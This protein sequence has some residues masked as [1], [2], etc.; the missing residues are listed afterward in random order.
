MR[1]ALSSVR[2]ARGVGCYMVWNTAFPPSDN[3]NP[4]MNPSLLKVQFLFLALCPL[5]LAGHIPTAHLPTITAKRQSDPD[6]KCGFEG[7]SDAYGLGI[8]LAMYIQWVTSPLLSCF[9][10]EGSSS[11]IGISNCFQ[12]SVFIALVYM[13][14]T[15]GPALQVSEAYLMIMIGVAGAY[16]RPSVGV[17]GTIGLV[18]VRLLHRFDRKNAQAYTTA[19]GGA[20]SIVLG[21]ALTSYCLWFVFTGMD[22]VQ[23]PP[24]S[25]F[26]YLFARVD[27]YHGMRIFLQVCSVVTIVTTVVVSI[28]RVAYEHWASDSGTSTP[29]EASSADSDSSGTSADGWAR[30]LGKVERK[31]WVAFVGDMLA[32]SMFIL[33]IE[34][35]IRWN[36]IQGVHQMGSTGQILPFVVSLGS[37]VGV[38]CR[39]FL[40]IASVG[41]DVDLDAVST[42]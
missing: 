3:L 2:A 4:V 20:V 13:T 40:Q 31:G 18:D 10:S 38:A 35:I 27:L 28:A 6:V 19:L 25:R 33:G 14:I 26:G 7:N 11:V 9:F 12:L 21:L 41:G 42:S 37:L 17:V 39:F 16:S 34:L 24:C 36:H 5:L 1:S 32:L 22:A 29:E 23:H 8:R 30:G 15:Q